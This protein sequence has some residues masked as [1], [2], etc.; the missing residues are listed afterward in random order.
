MTRI[1]RIWL[2]MKYRCGSPRCNNYHLYGGKGIRVCERWLTFENFLADMGHPPD[3]YSIERIDGLGPY[4]P[5]NCRWASRVE[6]NNNT[7]RN[8]I[9]EYGGRKQTVAQW[10]REI[11][12]HPQRLLTRL[13]RG[14]SE[15]DTLIRP[16]V[17]TPPPKQAALKHRCEGV[18]TGRTS[19]YRYGQQCSFT[20][21]VAIS[22]RWLC[23]A[24]AKQ[25]G[26]EAR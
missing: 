7:S 11:G 14:W 26:S 24:H 13:Q 4:E 22:D 15:S 1:Y 18:I 10:A 6:Q 9:I 17:P 21:K 23:V 2:A 20:A 3:G 19:Y 8:R 12:V 25:A 16:V 5:N